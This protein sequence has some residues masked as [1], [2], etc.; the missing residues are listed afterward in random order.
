MKRSFLFPLVLTAVMANVASAQITTK[1][2]QEDLAKQKTTF[3]K[4]SDR[5][6]IGYFGVLTTPTLYDIEKGNY[7]YAATSKGFQTYDTNRD[8]IPTNMWNQVNFNFNYGGPMN[9][10]FIP[11]W[12]IPLASVGARAE[13]QDTGLITLEDFLVGFQGSVI[14]SEDK[15]FNLWIRPGVRLPTSQGS[16]VSHPVFGTLNQNLEL[17]YL[18][19]YD[20]NKTWQLGIFGQFR[21]WIY[22]ER[23]N[24]SRFQF[25]TAPYVQY[26]MNDTTRVQVYYES[27]LRNNRNWESINNKKPIFKDLYQNFMVGVSKDITPKFNIFPYISVL[28]DVAPITNKSVWFGA[29]ISYQIK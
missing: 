29:W 13:P 6:K 14:T 7:E 8:S 21:A 9:F 17:A 1:P 3:E 26:T 12:S 10:V 20:F 5:I 19:T 22:E 23:Y 2:S 25:Y 15:K 4:F 24:I 11:R 28:P 16:R 27:I 18:P